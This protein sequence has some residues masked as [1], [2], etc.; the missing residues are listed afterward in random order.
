MVLSI[1]R[2]VCLLSRNSCSADQRPSVRRGL[3]AIA[4]NAPAV[5]LPNAKAA[6]RFF[7]FFTANIRNRNTRRAY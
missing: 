1:I 2:S 4:A 6:E 7:D 5:F 3:A